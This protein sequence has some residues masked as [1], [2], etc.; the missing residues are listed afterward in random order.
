MT[1]G[2]FLESCALA[3][4]ALC[5]DARTLFGGPLRIAEA[6]HETFAP[7]VGS[8]FDVGGRRLKLVEVAVRPATRHVEQF[9]LIFHGPGGDALPDGSHRTTH[10]ALGTFDLTV[11]GVGMPKPDR[12]TYQAAFSRLLEQPHR[13]QPR[14]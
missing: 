14:A 11:I 1:R 10:H 9:S 7:H 6:T 3:L 5:T 12:R 2:V 8:T 13:A 4:A